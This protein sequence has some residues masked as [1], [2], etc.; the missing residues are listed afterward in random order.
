[1]KP[2]LRVRQLVSWPSLIREMSASPTTMSPDDGASSPA[3]RLSSVVLPDPDGPM[4]ATYSPGWTSRLRSCRTS[5]FSLPRVKY[6]CT[7][8]TR[9]IGCAMVERTPSLLDVRLTRQEPNAGTQLGPQVGIAFG[10]VDA[11]AGG[12]AG[13]AA[14]RL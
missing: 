8:E 1:M 11:D 2:M 7:C 5:I 14:V 3:I 6:L 9:T 13:L 10:H 12:H 4:R